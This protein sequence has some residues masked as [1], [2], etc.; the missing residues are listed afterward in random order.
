MGLARFDATCGALPAATLTIQWG[1]AHVWKVGGKMF[2]IGRV[3]KEGP[4]S[5]SFKASEMAFRLLPE[6]TAGIGPAPYLARA[7]WLRAAPGALPPEAL[8][9]YLAEAH[10]LVAG[11]LPRRLRHELGLHGTARPSSALSCS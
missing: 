7:G 9:A 10:R 4:A 8:A 5:V 1:D 3:E 2:A 11:G 6:T